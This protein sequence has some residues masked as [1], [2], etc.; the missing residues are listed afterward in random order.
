MGLLGA[1]MIQMIAI[2][3]LI[4]GQNN[5]GNLTEISTFQQMLLK[6]WLFM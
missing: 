5:E 4:F 2:G 1:I 6:N 3:D